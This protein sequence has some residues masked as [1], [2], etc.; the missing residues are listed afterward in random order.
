[1]TLRIGELASATRT[2]APA[3]RYYEAIGLLPSPR[4]VSGQRHYRDD[5]V[6]RLTFIRRCRDFGF[7]VE[8]VRTLVALA[9]DRDRSC[10][11]ARELAETHLQAVR[12]KIIE[13]QALENSIA[14]LMEVAEPDCAGGPGLECVVLE[15]LSQPATR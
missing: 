6:R 7:S 10:L 11:E 14:K 12:A 3:I 4:R 5:D 9:Q 15:R 2:S 1:M 13:L 8:Q